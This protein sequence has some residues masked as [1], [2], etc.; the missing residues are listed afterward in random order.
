MKYAVIRMNGKQYK[1]A[2]GDELLVGKLA[3]EDELEPEV[4]LKVSAGEA[5]IGQPVLS[6]AKVNLEVMGEEKGKKLHV[7]KY[8]SKSRYRRKLGFRPVFTRV[9]VKGIK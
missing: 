6:K 7:F 9:K 8:K 5:S 1:V 4:L 2:E 3:P